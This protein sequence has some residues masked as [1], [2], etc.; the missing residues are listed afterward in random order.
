[1]EMNQIK[2][3]NDAMAGYKYVNIMAKER[4]NS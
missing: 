1:M 2:V 4:E 3:R